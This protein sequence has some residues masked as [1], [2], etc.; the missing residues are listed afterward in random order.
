MLRNWKG[1]AT[2]RGGP[3]LRNCESRAVRLPQ[4]RLNVRGAVQERPRAAM[5]DRLWDWLRLRCKTGGD[6]THENSH[7]GDAI[8]FAVIAIVRI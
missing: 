8:A 5:R 3:A 7:P 1:M 4:R 2:F 6:R